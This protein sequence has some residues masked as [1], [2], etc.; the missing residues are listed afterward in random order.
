MSDDDGDDACLLGK[1]SRRSSS[2]GVLHRICSSFCLSFFLSLG[3]SSSVF[4]R[5]QVLFCCCCCWWKPILCG[6][7]FY[8]SDYYYF[9]CEF[10]ENFG[11]LPFLFFFLSL[12]L[13]SADLFFLENFSPEMSSLLLSGDLKNWV[14]LR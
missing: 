11:V 3:S 14:L 2:V 12:D 4:D 10:D 13:D 7:Q 8:V 1:R 6:N 9:S 5:F